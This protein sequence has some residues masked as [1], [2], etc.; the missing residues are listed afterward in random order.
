MLFN[1]YKFIFLFLPAVLI[2]Y[3]F[4]NKKKLITGA[5]VWLAFASLVFYA[6]WSVK[7][8][9]LLLGSIYFNYTSSKRIAHTHAV[10]TFGAGAKHEHSYIYVRA[11]RIDYTNDYKHSTTNADRYANSASCF[12]YADS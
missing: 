4:L 12:A 5:K 1:S 6:Y 3:F 7:Y 10:S 2:V 9:P 11:N 8:L